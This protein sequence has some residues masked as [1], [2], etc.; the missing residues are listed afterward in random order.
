M[1]KRRKMARRLIVI[2]GAMM[3]MILMV[4]AKKTPEASSTLLKMHRLYMSQPPHDDSLYNIL[5]VSPNATQA[6][7]T[8]SYRRLT[9][10]LHPDKHHLPR[11]H[12]SHVTQQERE[13]RLQRVQEA[14]EV[15]KDDSTRLP[16]HR[17]GLLDTSFAAFLLTG[18]RV[19]GTTISPSQDQ[20][21]L[22][23]M[24]GFYNTK[25]N[26]QQVCT[27]VRVMALFVCTSKLKRY[28]SECF[29]SR[30]ISWNEYDRL[31]KEPSTNR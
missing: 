11:R 28:F 18:G 30:L 6:E 24:M 1:M 29:F 8:K 7:I 19:Q 31:W 13:E 10:D 26:H 2:L 23:Q 25:Q 22:L 16:Y 9:R 4:H 27:A 3:T 17:F 20:E 21:R 5:S 15:L 14:Y 12:S